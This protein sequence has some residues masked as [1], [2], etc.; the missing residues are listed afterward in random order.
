LNTVFFLEGPD[1]VAGLSAN[2]AISCAR[3]M[4][5]VLERFLNLLDVVL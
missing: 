4:P 5:L 2:D 1:R 3:I